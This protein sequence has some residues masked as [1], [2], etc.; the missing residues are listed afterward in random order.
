MKRYVLESILYGNATYIFDKD[1]EE[2]SKKTKS[3]ILNQELQKGRLIHRRFWEKDLDDIF[4][5]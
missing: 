5:I 3:E 1:W 4:K 2:L